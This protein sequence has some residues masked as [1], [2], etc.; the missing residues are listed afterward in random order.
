MQIIRIDIPKTTLLRSLIQPI[1]KGIT[2]PPEIA[3][4]ISPEISFV[5]SGYFST[6]IEKTSGKIFATARPI[7]KTNTH[8]MIGEETSNM[9]DRHKIPRTEVHIKKLREEI[10]VSIIAPAKVPSIRPKK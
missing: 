4:I 6:V 8:A 7:R 1:S 5:L 10:L 9:A 2:A 3:I